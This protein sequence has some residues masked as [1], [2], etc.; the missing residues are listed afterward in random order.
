M[1]RVSMIFSFSVLA[2]TLYFIWTDHV[3]S[4]GAKALTSLKLLGQAGLNILAHVLCYLHQGILTPHIS[5]LFILSSLWTTLYTFVEFKSLAAPKKP[6]T[7]DINTQI[8]HIEKKFHYEQKRREL[9]VEI[10][11][12]VFF[13]L[14]TVVVIFTMLPVPYLSLFF[15][16]IQFFLSQAK[17][18]WLDN[19]ER[20]AAT[21][22][23]KEIAVLCNKQSDKDYQPAVPAGI[24][25]I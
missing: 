23:Q 6:E 18:M 1:P 25:A 21:H 17:I 3:A 22:M 11:L 24:A 15:A 4:T 12:L 19:E 7:L 2:Y 8:N 20:K 5:I 14:C 13:T 9:H 16:A 10:G